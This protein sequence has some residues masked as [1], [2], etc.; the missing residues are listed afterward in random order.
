M[1]DTRVQLEVEDWVRR[2]WML[3]HFGQL[4]SRERVRLSS[5]GFF[6][7]D[8]VSEDLKIVATISTSGAR[9]SG[10]KNAI[11]KM[12]K[13]RSDMYFLL[14][15]ETERRLVILTESDMYAQCQKEVAGGRV[16]KS[17][18]FVHAEIRDDLRSRLVT[19]RQ[20]ASAEITVTGKPPL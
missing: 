10:G 1:A 15:A 2:E 17:I 14:L 5:G 13:I 16:P 7:A 18:E 3:K 12:L 19:S 6:D 11:G 8:A 20:A 4:F 9:T